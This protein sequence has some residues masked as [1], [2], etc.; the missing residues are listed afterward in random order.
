MLTETVS[1]AW[2]EVTSS[3]FFIIDPIVEISQA[4]PHKSPRQKLW[5]AVLID[6]FFVRDAAY[7]GSKG[8][9]QQYERDRA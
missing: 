6:A 4:T 1:S 7:Q 5:W 2:S 3:N 9:Q 8:A